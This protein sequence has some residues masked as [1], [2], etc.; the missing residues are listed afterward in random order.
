MTLEAK[1]RKLMREWRSSGNRAMHF[2]LRDTL[3]HCA[4]KLASILPKKRKR[5]KLK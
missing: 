3:E 4:D 5:K 2:I 1:C